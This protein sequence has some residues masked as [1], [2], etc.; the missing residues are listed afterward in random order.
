M[1]NIWVRLVGTIASSLLLAWIALRAAGAVSGEREH[2]TLDALLTTPQSD[3]AILWAKGW[4]S[5]FGVRRGWWLLG[6]IWGLGVLFQGLSP[7]CVIPLVACWAAHAALIAGIGLWF[8]LVSR[9][10]LRATIYTFLAL[11]V[12]DAGPYLLGS[13]SN[14]FWMGFGWNREPEWSES[15]RTFGISAPVSLW[16]LAC[17]WQ[18]LHENLARYRAA[19]HGIPFTLMM[20]AAVW[21]LIVTQFA[22]LTG[23][24]GPNGMRA[25]RHRAREVD[26]IPRAVHSPHHVS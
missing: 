10:T 13:V 5:I 4:G 25:P 1:F 17:R 2:Q 22:R 7:L 20:A 8:S 18:D 23:R 14:L 12:F 21:G 26:S 24:M 3:G 19:M 9:S 11:A 16:T 6:V 15:I